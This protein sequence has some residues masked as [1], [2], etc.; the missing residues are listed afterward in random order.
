M[1]PMTANAGLLTDELS[2]LI[3]AR[4]TVHTPGRAAPSR[5]TAAAERAK[6]L[7]IEV[8]KSRA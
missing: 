7:P 6:N 8:A 1:L 3:G 5:T 2:W 4:S